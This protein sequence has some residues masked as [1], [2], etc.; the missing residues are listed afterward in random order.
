MRK[1]ILLVIIAVLAVMVLPGLGIGQP[2]ASHG[3]TPGDVYMSTDPNVCHEETVK[4]DEVGLMPTAV[5]VRGD[6]HVLVYFS[7][8][9]NGFQD[10]TELVLTLQVEGEGF[11]E[12]SPDWILPD[13]N[14]GVFNA[15]H[16]GGTIMWTF[17]SVPA[18]EYMVQA[19]A[20]LAAFQ[21]AIHGRS[22]VA[23][24]GCALTAFVMPV[25]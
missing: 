3:G 20:R 24:Q 12:R 11:A 22:G 17:P 7:A 15:N 14:G 5:T 4:T 13:N 2:T 21:G 10:N 9:W 6:S 25:A 8:T 18:G 1:T 16:N 19:I 23:I